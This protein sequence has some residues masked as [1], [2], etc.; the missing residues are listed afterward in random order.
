MKSLVFIALLFALRLL[1]VA[2]LHPNVGPL[3]L[4]VIKTMSDIGLFLLL[5]VYILLIF[6]AAFVALNHDSEHFDTYSKAILTLFYAGLG[7]SQDPMNDSIERQELLTT[8]LFLV[9]VILS[10]IILVNLLIAIMTSTWAAIEE[11]QSAQYQLLKVR[12][13]NEYLHMSSTEQLPPPF[14]LIGTNIENQPSTNVVPSG[15]ILVLPLKY[16]ASL[17]AAAAR[18]H[19]SDRPSGLNI[20]AVIF[21][22]VSLLHA[23]IEALLFTVAFIPVIALAVLAKAGEKMN[24]ALSGGETFCGLPLPSLGPLGN[25]LLLHCLHSSRERGETGDGGDFVFRG[26]RDRGRRRRYSPSCV[27]DTHRTSR[28]RWHP[29]S[30]GVSRI[31]ALTDRRVA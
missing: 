28:G 23:T 16:L 9:Y 12:V 29:H 22:L 15:A 1:Q 19:D 11:T 21:L 2:S 31:R 14:N 13:I 10:S 5:Y 3:I 27:H 24:R 18:L 8:C 4:A 17:I 6:A 20:S 26:K 7:D 30:L 25:S